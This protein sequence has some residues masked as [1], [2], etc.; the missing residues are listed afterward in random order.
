MRSVNRMIRAGA[1]ALA[2]LLVS[3]SGF[4]AP[5]RFE[6]EPK[7]GYADP[8]TTGLSPYGVFVGLGLRARPVAHLWLSTSLFSYAGET[9]AGDGPDVTYRARDRAYAVAFDATWRFD[10][11]PLFIEPGAE[12]GASWIFGSTYVT[13]A[14]VSDGH[15][16]GNFGPVLRVAVGIRGVALG[17]EGAALFV[18]STVAAPVMRAA[19]IAVLSF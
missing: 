10:V 8:L 12:V 16:A 7:V 19:A 6:L 17:A 18:P 9:A 3:R 4:A 15:V 14:Q 2:T 11:G 5:P 13:P 1:T